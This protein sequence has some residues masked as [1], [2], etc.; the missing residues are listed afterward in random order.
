MADFTLQWQH[1]VVMRETRVPVKPKT[2]IIWPF[3]EESLLIYG[4]MEKVDNVHKEM[5]N[6]SREMETESNEN[7][8]DKN[9]IR[10]EEFL[11]WVSNIVKTG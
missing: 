7:A 5:K 6:F 1:W 2:F 11:Q 4:L 9:D 3:T 10:D 8:T